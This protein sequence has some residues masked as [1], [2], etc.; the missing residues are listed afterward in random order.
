[1]DRSFRE[2]D[3]LATQTDGKIDKLNENL[4]R[5]ARCFEEAPSNVSKRISSSQQKKRRPE[6][7]L[8][9]P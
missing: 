6:A 2:L 1:M 9:K 5:V 8:L 7:P 4:S 3:T